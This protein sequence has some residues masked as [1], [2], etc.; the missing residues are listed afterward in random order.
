M[1]SC[2][3]LLFIFWGFVVKHIQRWQ[4]F[5]LSNFKTLIPFASDLYFVV[6]L[7]VDPVKAICLSFQFVFKDFFPLSLMFCYSVMFLDRNLI[8]FQGCISAATQHPSPRAN[9]LVWSYSELLATSGSYYSGFEVLCHF[10]NQLFYFSY[11]FF[12]HFFH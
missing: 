2:S 12:I 6:Y 9:I 1:W 11:F 10:Q 5:S 3:F 8:E 7:T 4:L